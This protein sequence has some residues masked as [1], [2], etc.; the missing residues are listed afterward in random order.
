MAPEHASVRTLPSFCIGQRG[1]RNI[2]EKMAWMG[3]A[4]RRGAQ[5]AWFAGVAA[6]PHSTRSPRLDIPAA[7]HDTS[8]RRQEDGSANEYGFAD[9]FVASFRLSR[10][11][12]RVAAGRTG[13]WGWW[14]GAT[15]KWPVKAASPRFNRVMLPM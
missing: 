1:R 14:L 3:V 15:G 5:S 7:R 4:C 2:V 9:G 12:R 11:L 10:F 8:L 6:S 13:L